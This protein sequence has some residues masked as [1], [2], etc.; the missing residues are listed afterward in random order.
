MEASIMGH[1]DIASYLIKKGAVVDSPAASGVT[2]LWLAAGEGRHDIVQMLIDQVSEGCRAFLLCGM[3]EV[4]CF[5]P[6][7]GRELMST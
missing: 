7:D 5:Y 3:P 6:S 4:E 2:A 1:K